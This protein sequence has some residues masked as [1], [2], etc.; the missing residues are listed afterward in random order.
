MLSVQTLKTFLV[1]YLG[2]ANGNPA[3]YLS[4][5]LSGTVEE[6]AVIFSRRLWAAKMLMNLPVWGAHPAEFLQIR[7]WAFVETNS[8]GSHQRFKLPSWVD[9]YLTSHLKGSGRWSA[10]DNG[11]YWKAFKDAVAAY[12]THAGPHEVSRVVDETQCIFLLDELNR[13]SLFAEAIPVAEKIHARFQ[14]AD[15]L[16]RE[17][18]THYPWDLDS[19]ARKLKLRGLREFLLSQGESAYPLHSYMDYVKVYWPPSEKCEDALKAYFDAEFPPDPTQTPA[20]S[21]L[22]L[23]VEGVPMTFTALE[24][25]DW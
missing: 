15:G 3:N 6:I 14:R 5:L 17:V 24:S 13:W 11:G 1:H 10:Q 23:S 2:F 22:P 7:T 20:P 8:Q 4:V 21:P 16:A 12:P 18:M 25:K 9:E 19:D